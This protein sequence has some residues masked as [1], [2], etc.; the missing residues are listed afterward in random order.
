[1]KIKKVTY[2]GQVTA[3]IATVLRRSEIDIDAI[4]PVVEK[5]IQRVRKEGDA[6]LRAFTLDFDG[7]DLRD[8][9]LKVGED[10]LQAAS[11]QLDDAIKAAIDACAR[12]IRK[13]HETQMP[14]SIWME[15]I[16]PGVIAGEK[17]TPIDSVA[18]YVPRGKG[19]F[20]S[21][22]LMLGI[23]ASVTG[24]PRAIVCTPPTPRRRHRSS[25][26]LCGR[27]RRPHG[28]LSDRRRPGDRRRG[29]S[30]RNRFPRLPRSWD[31][32]IPMERRPSGFWPGKSTPVSRRGPAS[33]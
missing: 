32:A 29:P 19:S 11:G 10:E 31:P 17:S 6:A 23:P 2:D 13:F 15:E 1:M 33:P 9:P 20:P 8:R 7:V 18:L 24:V 21:V 28:N 4:K 25:D 26:R 30:A 14:P 5:I 22:M 12:N 3:E 27:H 16:L